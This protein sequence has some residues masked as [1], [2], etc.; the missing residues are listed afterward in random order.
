MSGQM[1]IAEHLQ[2]LM[3]RASRDSGDNKRTLD[4]WLQRT[5]YPLSVQLPMR[6]LTQEHLVQLLIL[7]IIDH[8]L[9]R[10]TC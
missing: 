10:F 6:G 9:N 3:G 2:F 5:R 7:V 1:Q 4:S 8:L